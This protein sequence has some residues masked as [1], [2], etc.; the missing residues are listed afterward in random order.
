MSANTVAYFAVTL[1]TNPEKLATYLESPEQRIEMV[2]GLNA[3]SWPLSNEERQFLFLGDFN[4]IF[5]YL[6]E[7]GGI[8]GI[9]EIMT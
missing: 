9:N 4:E 7:N 6:N 3:D 5:A 1:A 2:N 8:R